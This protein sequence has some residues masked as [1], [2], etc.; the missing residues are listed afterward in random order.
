M[1]TKKTFPIPLVKHVLLFLLTSSLA[2]SAQTIT[3]KAAITGETVDVAWDNNFDLISLD[4]TRVI[5]TAM[6]SG[7]YE[8]TSWDVSSNSIT[9]KATRLVNTAVTGIRSA[10]L[11]N[12]RFANAYIRNGLLILE[13]WDIDATGTI[14]TL[15]Q[16][17]QDDACFGGFNLVA[18]SSTRLVS[19]IENSAHRLEMAT[20]DVASNGTLTKFSTTTEIGSD[21]SSPHSVAVLSS[22]KFAVTYVLAGASAIS[23][24]LCSV[25]A[26]GLISSLDVETISGGAI[27]ARLAPLSSNRF[28]LAA[29]NSF[30]VNDDNLFTFSVSSSNVIS[31][32]SST[33]S[34]VSYNGVIAKINSSNILLASIKSS[35]D[36]LDL[37]HFKVAS[38][39][40]FTFK[41]EESS[42]FSKNVRAAT[43]IGNTTLGRIVTGTVNS[44]DKLRLISWDVDLS[45]AKPE[46]ATSIDG[47]ET[48]PFDIVA[49]PNPV[50][51]NVN[52]TFNLDENSTVRVKM[53][54]TLGEQIAEIANDNYNQGTHRINYSVSSLPAGIYYYSMETATNQVMNKI[55]ITH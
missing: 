33:H 12:T 3:K 29:T 55:V 6:K 16:T 9:K 34:V 38:N 31:Q 36:L 4:E 10:K 44:S 42:E 2:V 19:F 1:K 23:V 45:Q 39:G 7:K 51:D 24:N 11:S 35:N 49:Y 20:W 21:V 32:L 41:D 26:N 17:K 37:E 47:N 27:G 30:N 28:V 22:G 14:F 43:L 48:L 54:N 25:A 5:T 18:V 15:K 46:A 53:Y 52:F 40:A 50:S 13:V 8:L